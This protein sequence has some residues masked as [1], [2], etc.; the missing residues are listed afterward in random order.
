MDFQAD[1]RFVAAVEQ[2]VQALPPEIAAKIDRLV[3]ITDADVDAAVLASAEG[4]ARMR[5]AFGPLARISPP[6]SPKSARERLVFQCRNDLDWLFFRHWR[7]ADG[8]LT[9]GRPLEVFHDPL[10]IAMR[11]AVISRLYPKLPQ[12]AER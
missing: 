11:R 5:A 8:W 1:A 4:H 7:L 2:A 3:R 10:A 9:Q 6:Q 12:M